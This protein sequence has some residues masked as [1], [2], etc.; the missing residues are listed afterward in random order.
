MK[1]N[2]DWWNAD[3]RMVLSIGLVDDL[4]NTAIQKILTKLKRSQ[5]EGKTKTQVLFEALKLWAGVE[6]PAKTNPMADVAAMLERVN[7]NITIIRNEINELK[8]SGVSVENAS[9][10][11]DSMTTD[12]N[13]PML[14]N[15]FNRFDAENDLD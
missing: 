10:V 14:Q 5:R 12:M 6:E 15:L 13:N 3:G 7:Q 9:N 8:V 2:D 4:D 11:L 1:R